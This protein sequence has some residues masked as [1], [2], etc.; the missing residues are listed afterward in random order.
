MNLPL[1]VSRDTDFDLIVFS[2]FRNCCE[3]C[4][5]DKFE[6]YDATHLILR[7]AVLYDEATGDYSMNYKHHVMLTRIQETFTSW[8]SC[9]TDTNFFSEEM[10][11]KAMSPTTTVQQKQDITKIPYRLRDWYVGELVVDEFPCTIRLV[12]WITVS[13][14]DADVTRQSSWLWVRF[15]LLPKI[16]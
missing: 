5:C 14:A 7:C 15:S 2:W 9:S 8:R 6:H 12:K 13:G 16:R 4:C 3:S 11:I 1:T 10:L